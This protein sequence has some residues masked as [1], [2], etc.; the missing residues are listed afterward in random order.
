M[1]YT[2]A[3]DF[4]KQLT[5]FGINLGLDRI[6]QLLS[7]MGNPHEKL[8]IVHVG[9]TNGKGSTCAMICGMLEH[10]GYRTGL[11]TSP[12][13]HSYRE[14][15][16]VNGIPVDEKRL[17]DLITQVRPL[18]ENMTARG[19]EHPTE[20]EV[21]T[22]I[23]F[24]YFYEE[25]VDVAVIEVGLGGAIDSTNVVFPLVSVI[26]NVNRDHMDYL[27][28][29]IS[30]IA[31][32]KAGII[33]ENSEVI[34]GEEEREALEVIEDVCDKKKV[35]LHKIGREINYSIK[36]I[37]IN[38]AEFDYNGKE[39]YKDLRIKLLGD[40]QVRNAVMAVAAIELLEFHGF[41]VSEKSIRKGL[42]EV[43][44]PA[45]LELMKFDGVDVIL[46]V[47]HNVS[48]IEGLKN[49]VGKYLKYNKLILI[50]G[51]LD[52]KEREQIIEKIAP[53]ADVFIATKPISTRSISWEEVAEFARKYCREVYLES[54]ITSA[55]GE[56][57]RKASCGDLICITGSFY[58]ACDARWELLKKENRK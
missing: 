41:I 49:F 47:A 48:G 44:W 16:K 24:K 5:K 20:F 19:F 17:A 25:G 13:I 36:S 37:G 57:F 46:D 32:V 6:E 53:I 54:D 12:H 28:D 50:I 1:K 10:S 38:G 40:H 4:L 26:T 31:L 14:R 35:P 9:G 2:E 22:A 30:E 42:E 34:T 18:L 51:L 21:N 7:L 23:A 43:V 39:N 33:K 45:R 11:F 55:V 58:M 15:F 56:A 8:N 3:L 29:T 27:G 52:D